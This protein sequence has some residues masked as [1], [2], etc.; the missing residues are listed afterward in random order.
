MHNV[1]LSLF[2]GFGSESVNKRSACNVPSLRA[3][4]KHT[5]CHTP[6]RKISGIHQGQATTVRIP[7]PKTM[8]RL[9]IFLISLCVPIQ[10]LACNSMDNI[11]LHVEITAAYPNPLENE[12]EW[13]E[14]SNTGPVSVNLEH[15][16]LEDT[17][18]HA[19]PLSG[20]I[21]PGESIHITEL[22]FQLN[23]GGDELILYTI[24]GEWVDS[25]SYNSSLAGQVVPLSIVE[26]ISQENTEAPLPTEWPEYSEAV[27]N[28]EGTD[29]SEEWI[30]L[31]N[32][33]AHSIQLEGLELDDS[34]GGSRAYAL[35][36]SIEA[37]S[38]LVISVEDSGLSLNNT[39][40]E[41]RLLLNDEILWSIPYSDVVEGL[42]Y[43]L[44]NGSYEWTTP[45]PGSPNLS[46]EL[47]GDLSE[48][49]E[50][51]EVN[52]N[53]EGPDAENEWIEITNGGD[54]SVDLGNWSI[55][56]GEGGS[57]PYFIPEGTI[58]APGE[59]IIIERTE[60]KIALNNSREKIQL[61]DYTQEL[62]D[63]IEYESTQE[64]QSY[65]KIEIEEVQNL[66]ASANSLGF[67]SR[68]VW[69]WTEPS[70][71]KANPSWKEYLGVV[72]SYDKGMLTLLIQN[73]ELI[74]DTLENDFGELLF[75]P[76]N[77]VMI[78]ASMG[79]FVHQVIRAELV[80]QVST[81]TSREFPWSWIIISILASGVLAYEWYKSKSQNHMILPS[82]ELLS[83]G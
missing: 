74:F 2:K 17:T 48:E 80:E 37:K 60:S 32:P 75:Q 76:G 59:S 56:D 6:V 7:N 72:Q 14:L 49:I 65:S 19:M 21:L 13:V 61:F 12:E 43:A 15:Y 64:G 83:Q 78:Q 1:V 57:D 46:N 70:P 9:I 77:T 68:I 28:P 24:E 58:I 26:E 69:E 27:P 47:E 73:S 40:D 3:L 62:M 5:K 35:T 39:T 10:A 11:P 29:T 18:A 81:A 38:Y 23:N 22:S 50:L 71:G 31:Y 55:D 33:Y 82:S 41:V 8:K 30:E 16:T 52:P 4:G 63:E 45:T 34:E 36:G 53:P 79:E 51:T 25:F 67:R 42:S 54:Q 20:E 66:Q 44:V